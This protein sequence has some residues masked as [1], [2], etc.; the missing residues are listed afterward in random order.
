MSENSRRITLDAHKGEDKAAQLKQIAG[1]LQKLSFRD[2]N[3]LCGLISPEGGSQE[4]AHKL[5]NVADVILA[6]D[7]SR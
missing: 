7:F 5:L 3:R 1:L 2:M 6:P 4:L